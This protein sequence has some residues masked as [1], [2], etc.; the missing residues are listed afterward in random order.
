MDSGQ[1]ARGV[2]RS[3]F[4]LYLA[5][6]FCSGTAMTMF[7]AAVAWHVFA[8]SHSAFHLGLIGLVQFVPALGLSLLGGA[9]AD[10]YDRRKVMM[11][12]QAVPLACGAALCVIT[13]RGSA[14]LPLLYGMILL[15]AV[16]AAFDSPSR[17]AL[18]P[19][20]V[21]REFFPRAVT[22]ASTNQALAFVTGPA[23]GGFI[24]AGTGVGAVYAVYG[25]LIVGSLATLAFIR[26]RRPDSGKTA[27]S[28]QAIRQ[29][30][31]FVRRRQVI[32]G[33]MTLDMFAV[34]F[35]GASALLPI[36][37]NDILH[38]GARGYGFLTSSLELGALLTSLLLVVLP[39]IRRAGRALLIAVGAYGMATIVF[40]LSRWFPLSVLAYIAVG[41]ADQV[42]VVMRSTAIQLSTPDELRGRVSSVNFIFIGASNQLGAVESGFVAALTNAPFSVVSGGIGCLIVLALVSATLPELRRYRV[43]T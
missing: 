21:S 18:L 22:L 4:R 42:S 16:A 5:S 15:V 36:Y 2:Q 7:R 29:G 28:L 31:A 40:G 8:L 27:L 37:A 1:G 39:P 34:I 23:A 10:T 14:T 41:V 12:A 43:D 6:R 20:L 25:S 13:Q 17:A 35:G 11:L 32:L 26:P 38:V 30:L 33:C 24:I 19:T 9:V 3:D